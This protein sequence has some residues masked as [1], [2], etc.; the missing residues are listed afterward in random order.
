MDFAESLQ[1]L[2][3]IKDRF[4]QLPVSSPDFPIM[5]DTVIDRLLE[6]LK[7]ADEPRREAASKSSGGIWFNQKGR[8]D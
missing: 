8:E 7:S 1:M 6:D 4:A 3:N 2:Q 5:D